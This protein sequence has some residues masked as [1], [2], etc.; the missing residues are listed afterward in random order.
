MNMPSFGDNPSQYTQKIETVARY[1]LNSE[2]TNNV[3]L[4]NST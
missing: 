1:L 2:E 4:K 3:V